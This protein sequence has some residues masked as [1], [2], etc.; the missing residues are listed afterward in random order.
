MGS[1]DIVA[2]AGCRKTCRSKICKISGKTKILQSRQEGYVME[3][4]HTKAEQAKPEQVQIPKIRCQK[5]T[6]AFFGV[7][8]VEK[9]KASTVTE[10]RWGRKKTTPFGFC[11][12]QGL[13]TIKESSHQCSVNLYQFC[14]FVCFHLI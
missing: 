2:Q 4:E 7:L 10:G 1:C 5:Q 11:F 13:R 9:H 8:G 12:P 14:G 6:R 3:A